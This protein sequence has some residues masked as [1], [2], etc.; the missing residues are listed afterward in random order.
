M[1]TER[2]L[3]KALRVV[4]RFKRSTF[5]YSGAT[6]TGKSVTLPRAPLPAKTGG[7]HKP[8]P[9]LRPYRKRKH[10]GEDECERE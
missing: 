8:A 2:A 1:A 3:R 6:G 4:E 7:A 9:A 5:I 10:K